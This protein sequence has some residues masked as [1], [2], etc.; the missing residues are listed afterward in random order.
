MVTVRSAIVRERWLS[1]LTWIQTRRRRRSSASRSRA[2][3]RARAAEAAAWSASDSFCWSRLSARWRA[4]SARASS[5]SSARSAESARTVTWSGRTSRNPPDTKNNCSSPSLRTLTD[6]G[7]S[8]VSSG[9]CR[10]RTPSSPSEPGATTKSASPRNLRPS[11]VTISTWSLSATLLRLLA[12]LCSGFRL[13]LRWL[14]LRAILCGGFRLIGRL[15]RLAPAALALRRLDGLIDGA[16]HVERLLG[17]VVVLAIEDLAEAADRLLQGHIFPWSVGEHFGHEE[18]LRQ[19]A[20]D[21]AGTGHQQL[22]ILRQF[23][24]AKDGNDV[25]QLL[26]ALQHLLHSTRD[27]IMLFTHDVRREEPGERIER[28]DRGVDAALDDRPGKAHRGAKVGER[29]R[30]RRVGIVVRRDEDRLD[31]RDRPLLGR[32]DSLL[33][34]AHFG[35]QRRL[36][37]D[38]RR[39]AAKQRRDLAALEHVAEDLVDEQHYVLTELVPEVLRKRETGQAHPGARTRRLVHLAENERRFV[40]DPRL[41]HFQPEAVALAGA[42][43]DA[44]EDAEA[45]MLLSDIADQ[46]HHDDGLAYPRAAEE[47]DL[48]ALGE[49]GHEV[50][51]LDA[52]LEHGGIG[53]L[54]ADRRRKPVDREADIRLDFAFPIDWI[55]DD[56]HH[57]AE[58]A[59]ADR[60]RDRRTGVPDLVAANETVG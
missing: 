48:A 28:V 50:D 45:A 29:G 51:D 23:V 42:L 15:R 11:T 2:S 7:A 22:V 31:G 24:H 20:L 6:P 1:D 38:G 44:G 25:L 32:G 12:A 10:G 57:P 53:H 41:I 59:L 60:D 52:G 27:S 30:D 26:V 37:A 49:G 9:M 21:L 35:G 5:I 14:R 36:V 55:A 56:A 34:I 43:S 18:R 16:H 17:K 54:L 58:R 46:L 33:E 4:S 40:D 8:G 13:L 39:D 47:A 3:A 19:K